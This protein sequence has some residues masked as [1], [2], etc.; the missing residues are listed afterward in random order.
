[1]ESFNDKREREVPPQGFLEVTYQLGEDESL[2]MT[3][4]QVYFMRD[5]RLINRIPVHYKGLNFLSDIY[6]PEDRRSL[7]VSDE[8]HEAATQRMAVEGTYPS[9]TVVNEATGVNKTRTINVAELLR[10]DE[11]PVYS[12]RARTQA[13]GEVLTFGIETLI[14]RMAADVGINPIGAMIVNHQD[15]RTI[16]ESGLEGT[17]FLSRDNV[18]EDERGNRIRGTE[19]IEKM[20]TDVSSS[21]AASPYCIIDDREGRPEVIV[22]LASQPLLE[23]V[24]KSLVSMVEERGVYLLYRRDVIATEEVGSVFDLVDGDLKMYKRLSG[25]PNLDMAIYNAYREAQRVFKESVQ[26]PEV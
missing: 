4:D 24:V 12:G 22:H 19:V 23:A 3:H 11:V 5:S 2:L 10:F 6:R 18:S 26:G 25:E 21:F 15:A 9:L 17:T 7:V 1:M 14:K 20:Q 13:G 8:F 16:D